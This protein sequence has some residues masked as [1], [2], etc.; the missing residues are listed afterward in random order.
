[1]NYVISRLRI[2]GPFIVAVALTVLCIQPAVAVPAVGG[3]FPSLRLPMPDGNADRTYLGIGGGKN[4]TVGDITAGLVVIEFF[5]M[6]CPHC[7]A[8]APATVDLFNRIKNDP[9]LS[10]RV[11]MIG[12]GVG[13]SEY[14][15]GIFKKKYGI[16]FP[17]F[18]DGEYAAL[19]LLDI[20]QTPTYVVVKI[21]GGKT[22]VAYTQ[23]G[24]IMD[25]GSFITTLSSLR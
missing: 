2:L 19:D 17:L 11:R 25:V 20:R 22:T 24:R 23:I 8:D 21:A 5:S 9:L 6:Y 4:F 15:V 10:K 1:M 7:Q 13:N 3:P 16:P 12:I 18:P 14:E